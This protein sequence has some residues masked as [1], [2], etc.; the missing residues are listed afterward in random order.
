M[1][2]ELTERPLTARERDLVNERLADLGSSAARTLPIAGAVSLVCCGVLAALTLLASDAPRAFVLAFWGAFALLFTGWI[3]IPWRNQFRR[4]I[5]GLAAGLAH[6]RARAARVQ[7][8][9]VVSFDE[10]EDEG[11]C[12]AFDV[13]DG[14]VLFVLGQEFYESEDFPNTDFSLIDVFAPGQTVG[15]LLFLKDGQRLEPERRISSD[16]KRQLS[17]PDHLTI[18]RMSLEDLE[19]R[20][21]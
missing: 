2:A 7:S 5:T 8:T 20:L 21:R 6:N 11:A 9:R 3:G 12:Y 4:K 15:D 1:S 10:I 19:S 18:D 17:I 13:G 16:L 14:Q